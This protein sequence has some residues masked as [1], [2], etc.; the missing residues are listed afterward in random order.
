MVHGTPCP[1]E[2]G[3][4]TSQVPQGSLVEVSTGVSGSSLKGREMQER[5]VAAR[6]GSDSAVTLN[7]T[8]PA[9]QIPGFRVIV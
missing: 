4:T 9:S 1:A 3:S 5:V 2:S 6:P 7:T 8:Q